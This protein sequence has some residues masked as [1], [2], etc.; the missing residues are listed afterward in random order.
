[1]MHTDKNIVADF[2]LK[3]RFRIYRHLL[4]QLVLITMTFNISLDGGAD[5]ARDTTS[6]IAWFSYYLLLN[7]IIYFNLYV[8]SPL[9][10]EK[11]KYQKYLMGVV[12][13]I[14]VTLL[15]IV[16]LQAILYDSRELKELHDV[17]LVLLNLLSSIFSVGLMIAGTSTLLLLRHWIGY[18]QRIDELE[19]TTL[20]SELQ[21][22]KR[23]I[24]PHFLF[25]M[26]NNAN[27]LLKK[28]PEEASQL[29][30]KLEDLLRYQINDSS[31]DKVLLSSDIHFLNDFLNLEK[32]RRDK[33]EYVISKEGN[34]DHVALPPLL[35]IP[36]VENAVKHNP[37][38][39][40]ESYVH[41]VFKVWKD[42]LV[43]QCINSKPIKLHN[44]TKSK[45]GGL[46]LKNIRRRLELLYPD[47]HTL[48][49][50]ENENIYKVNLRLTL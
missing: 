35:F 17:S 11:E 9:Y 27:V 50:E 13:L 14:I 44:E 25:N 42:E 45:A 4:L 16:A 29:L 26:L 43:F 19:S 46:G 7:S 2:L 36:F 39:E 31:R 37:D 28:N 34:I 24:N 23:Q 12:L 22:L 41:L 5:I 33:F 40:H 6:A 18:N 20:Q 3:P 32:I 47:R 48:E 15:G 38:S 49:I 1:M 8:L 30:F 10:L 21:H